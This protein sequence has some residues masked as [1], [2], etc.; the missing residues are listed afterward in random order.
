MSE[1][2][3]PAI[4]LR[5]ICFGYRREQVLSEVSLPIYP[6]DYLVILG[7][8]GGGK[9]TLLRVLLGLLEPW[10]G[11]VVSRLPH[12]RSRL[13]YV[14]QYSTF[15]PGFPLRID[16]VA[17]MGRLGRRGLGRRYGSE[18]RA[19][20]R[21]ALERVRLEALA[22]QMVG[23]LS[24][25]QTQRLLLA[26]ALA[27][28]PEA[29]ILDE[30]MASLDAE[31]REVVRQVLVEL[32][33]RMPVV[34]VTHDPAA[35]ATDIRH[36]ACLNRR[37]TY[38]GGAELTPGVLEETYGCPVELIAHGVPHRVLAPHAEHRNGQAGHG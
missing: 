9:T 19:A 3:L 7:P 24:G 37:L 35:V 11:E 28:E 23:E 27:S 8:N 14:P 17:L 20:A 12:G 22:Q 16:E 10:S 15:E 29:M 2:E 26:R 36:I 6:Q 13:G 25:G 18:D 5:G 1:K 34:V 38:H 21:Q 31:S 33:G 4:E 32:A 30:P